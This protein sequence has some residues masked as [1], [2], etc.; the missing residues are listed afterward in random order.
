MYFIHKVMLELQIRA[1]GLCYLFI[2]CVLSEYF[3]AS[4]VEG[5]VRPLRYIV[6][7]I[8]YITMHVYT[9]L[10]YCTENCIRQILQHLVGMFYN[11]LISP[12]NTYVYTGKCRAEGLQ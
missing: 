2:T 9:L 8:V 5:F 11:H 10:F 4:R 3:R 7:H 12:H 1:R 6:N